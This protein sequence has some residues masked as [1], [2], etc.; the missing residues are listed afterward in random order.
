MPGW[1]DFLDR[2]RPAGAPG[3]ASAA[4]IP[5][6]RAAAAAAELMPLLERLDLA[7]DEAQRLRAA[8]REQ[9][10]QVRLAGRD[11]SATLVQRVREHAETV[12]AQIVSDDSMA[13]VD[14]GTTS[15]AEGPGDGRDVAR[16]L[17]RRSE[18]RL[19]EYVDQVV[20][21]VREMLAGLCAPVTGARPR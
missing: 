11:E 19:P 8:A 1:R 9:A 14:L 18:E 16:V 5:I 2:F 7:Q 10:A 21:V 3:A 15:G 4:A 6:D 13:G 20:A 12:A 17:T